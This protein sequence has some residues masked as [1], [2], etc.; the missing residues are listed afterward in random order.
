MNT[1][2]EELAQVTMTAKRT[3]GL[4]HLQTP[5]SKN[6]GMSCFEAVQPQ[7]SPLSPHQLDLLNFNEGLLEVTK[8]I[9]RK[10]NRV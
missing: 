9:G 4:G 5:P 2:A 8:T 10:F 1:E 7:Q 6:S 3:P